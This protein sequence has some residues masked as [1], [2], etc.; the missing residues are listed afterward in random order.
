MA[1]IVLSTGN[2]VLREVELAKERIAIGRG[3]HNDV[4]I[5]DGGVS[6]EHAV[7]VTVGDD[8][9]LED[10]NSTNGTQ[11]NGQPVKKHFLRDGDV[12]ELAGYHAL[13]IATV[14][15]KEDLTYETTSE[16]SSRSTA[17][18]KGGALIKILNGPSAGKEM[19]LTKALMTL[20][21]PPMR[22]AV[23]ARRLE[24]YYLT[25]IDGATDMSV[26]GESLGRNPRRMDNSDLIDLSGTQMRFLIQGKIPKQG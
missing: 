6:A 23:I 7:I 4:V 5:D 11:V 15:K 1:K 24:D 22:V 13:Y 16:T 19:K 18:V 26:N 2:T 14:E 9:F 20:G 17:S 25:N 8:A 10:L 12:M 21:H 3:S